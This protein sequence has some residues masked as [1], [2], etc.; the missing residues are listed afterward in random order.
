L[1]CC[2]D[3][4]WTDDEPYTLAKVAADLE[5]WSGFQNLCRDKGEAA[6]REVLQEFI[7]KYFLKVLKLWHSKVSL[8]LIHFIRKVFE[9]LG[10]HKRT[11]QSGIQIEAEIF[12]LDG[13]QSLKRSRTSCCCCLCYCGQY[14]T[15]SRHEMN[16]KMYFTVF[17]IQGINS[18]LKLIVP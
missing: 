3:E 8:F 15:D 1:F 13:T 4:V 11:R 5:S 7:A 10:N 18:T 17:A 12:S 9:M 2:R 6:G 16:K 14:Q